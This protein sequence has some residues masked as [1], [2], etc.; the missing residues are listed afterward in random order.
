MLAVLL[1]ATLVTTAC[2]SAVGPRMQIAASPDRAKVLLA[3]YTKRL[4]VG[5][6]VRVDLND[7]RRLKGI[8]MKVDEDMLVV[9][10]HTR[11]PEAPIEIPLDRIAA[12]DLEAGSSMGRTIAIGA[13]S[14]AGGVLAVFAILAVIF[15]GD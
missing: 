12:V 2:A 8:L 1:S 10:R 5:S 13:A 4:P 14:A 11:L 15:S 7:G 9:R 3:D 6:R